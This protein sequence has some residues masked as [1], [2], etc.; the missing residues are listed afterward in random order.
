[1]AE[2]IINKS[3]NMKHFHFLANHK[4]LCAVILFTG[5]GSALLEGMGISLIYPMFVNPTNQ[6]EI[7]FP[8]NCIMEMFV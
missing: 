1:M 7:P 3:E 6:A 8:L 5:I 4:I 2:K